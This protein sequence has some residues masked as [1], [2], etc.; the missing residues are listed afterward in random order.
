MKYK[1]WEIS[2]EVTTHWNEHKEKVDTN[3]TWYAKKRIFHDGCILAAIIFCLM[4]WGFGLVLERA[5]NG[6]LIGLFLAAMMLAM[7]FANIE[8]IN[9]SSLK[10]LKNRIDYEEA[11]K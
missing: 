5:L 8:N 11:Q 10:K 9:Q 2:S 6:F 4:G 7:G 1:N 3:K